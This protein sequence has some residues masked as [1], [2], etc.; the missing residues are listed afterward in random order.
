MPPD[1]VGVSVG[2]AVAVGVG[3]CVGVSVG[4]GEGS[5]GCL[6]FS[7]AWMRLPLGSYS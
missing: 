6:T 4:V 3:V 7:M 5:T 2:V 1:S